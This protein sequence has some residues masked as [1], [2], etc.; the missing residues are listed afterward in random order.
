MI[1]LNSHPNFEIRVFTPFAR[2]G[3]RGLN[4]VGDFSR[5]NRP[6]HNKT[7]TV[8]DQI[9][10]IG[11]R[12]IAAEYLAARDDVNFGDLD[13]VGVGLIVQDVSTQCDAYWDDEH[14]VPVLGFAKQ[15]EKPGRRSGDAPGAVGRVA[16][17]GEANPLGRRADSGQRSPRRGVYTQISL[18]RVTLQGVT[19]NSPQ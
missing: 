10:I 14:A 7:S 17:N 16:R 8:D 19:M 15:T 5:I 6:M 11:G 2:K 12:N 3:S 4:A 18:G 1:A 9:T 13:A